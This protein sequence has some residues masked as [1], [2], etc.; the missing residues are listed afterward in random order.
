[1]KNAVRELV[2]DVVRDFCLPYRIVNIRES[3][4]A[5]QWNVELIDLS[6]GNRTFRI[7]IR[8]A[9]G[10]SLDASKAEL[11]IRLLE[12][13][14][15]RHWSPWRQL[16]AALGRTRAVIT[17]VSLRRS[18]LKR[19]ILWTAAVGGSVTALG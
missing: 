4:E 19:L 14:G 18:V 12:C 17:R 16:W 15:Q 9:E 11:A 5:R 1:M 7:S 10:S 13:Q 2:E 3:Q 8:L 6:M